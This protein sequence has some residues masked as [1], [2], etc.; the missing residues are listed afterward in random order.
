MTFTPRSSEEMERAVTRLVDDSLGERERPALEAWAASHPEVTR[1][2]ATQRSVALALLAGGPTAPESLI[3]AVEARLPSGRR[4][5]KPG[6]ARARI[7]KGTTAATALVAVALATATVAISVAGHMTHAGPSIALAAKLAFAPAT[8]PAPASTS[9]TLLDVTYG[10]ITFPNYALRFGA[11]PTGQR[12]DRLGGRGALTV[13]YHLRGGPRLSY[14]I[15]SGR[16]V[17]LPRTVSEILFHGV[18]LH[19]ISAAEHLAVVT[20][21]RHGH[22]CVLAARASAAALIA[23]AEAPLQTSAA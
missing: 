13:F 2:V 14:T 18:H 17:P 4:S 15:Y 6:A 23:L 7:I 5:R 16:P 12:V 20:L 11:T 21:V 22:T 19:V 8:E 1:Q 9:A 3:T 10:G